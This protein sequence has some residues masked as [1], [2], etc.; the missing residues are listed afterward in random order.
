MGR[1]PVIFEVEPVV[2]PGLLRNHQLLF[3]GPAGVADVGD[4]DFLSRPGTRGKY[5]KRSREGA[6][7]Q[8]VAAVAVSPVGALPNLHVVVTIF[9]GDDLAGG[10]LAQKR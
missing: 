8:P 6:H 2:F 5:G 7:V 3:S 10:I 4:L 1:C 9:R